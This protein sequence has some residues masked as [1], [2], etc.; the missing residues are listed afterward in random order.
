MDK[1]NKKD[2]KYRETRK[3]LIDFSNIAKQLQT[4]ENL[5][6]TVNEILLKIIYDT[7]DIKEFNTFRQWKEKGYTIIKG[8]KAYLIW[9]QPVNK[10][11]ADAKGEEYSEGED[12]YRYFPVCYL[13]SDKQV[14][15]KEEQ[16]ENP[17][18]VHHTEQQK[19]R[20]P[21]YLPL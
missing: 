11:K 9:G 4:A 17:E 8:S 18:S 1:D 2:S 20:E 14:Y 19:Q 12:E 6:L 15:K 10:Q 7:K 13:F 3:R 21:E 5:D 16:S